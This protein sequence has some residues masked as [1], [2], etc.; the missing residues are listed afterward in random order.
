MKDE[1]KTKEQLINELV[2]LRRLF[3]EMEALEVRGTEAEDFIA[4]SKETILNSL[5]EHVIHQ[6]TEMKILW[7]NRA[8]C[9]SAGLALE[10]L[11][12]CHCYEIWPQRTDPCPGCPVLKAMKTGQR[13]EVEKITPDG[14]AR[15][16]QGSPVRD[17]N[18][19]VIGGIE[20]TLDIT[21]RKLV[22]EALRKSE[23]RYR[24]IVEDQT[25]MI[26]RFLPGGILTFVNDAYCRCCGKKREELIGRSFMSLIPEE[27][28]AVVE[29]N[30]ALLTQDSPV[31]TS[32]HQV[33][34]PDG[35]TGW[36]Q[37]SDRAIFN[38]KG[39]FIEYQSVGRDI[40]ER[41]RMEEALQK[42]HLILEQQVKERTAELLMKNEQLMKEIEERRQAERMLQESENKYRTVFETTGTATVIIEEDKIIS[43][44]NREFEKLSGYSKEEVEGKKSWTEFVAEDDLKK[45]KEY[46]RMRRLDSNA[47]PRNYEFEFIDRNGNVKDIFMTVAMI[48]GT[49][50]SVASFLDITEHKRMDRAL[51]ESERKYRLI[52]DNVSDVIWTID[53]NLRYTYVSPSVTHL[54]GY[55][56]EEVMGQTVEMVLTPASLDIANKALAEELNMESKSQKDLSRSRVLE[57]EHICKDGSTVRVEIKMTFLRD[58]EGRSVG[59]LGVTRDITDRKRAE[60]ALHESEDQLRFLSSQL[61]TTQENERKRIAQELHDSIGQILTTI[62]FGVENV[63]SPRSKV[64]VPP[65]VDVKKVRTL[66]LIAQNG[67]EE[68]RRICAD[69]WPSILD[70]LGIPAAISRLC[71]EFQIIY[72]DIHIEQQINVQ[73]NEVPDFLKIV[74]YRVLQEALNNIARHSEAHLVYVSLNKTKDTIELSVKDN[75]KGFNIKDVFYGDSFTRRL[76]SFNMKE[77]TELS[78]GS[79][80]VKSIRGEGTTILSSWYV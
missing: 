75:G 9:E 65:D 33:I 46:H 22:E 27:D 80:V 57:L 66:I 3:A 71:R 47:A 1:E 62:K 15:V 42:S 17:S 14:R 56:V 12:G 74:I 45:M 55:G 64:T 59:I 7:A 31:A 58:S 19:N 51:Q 11:V 34:L 25:E 61:L 44:A 38:N 76:G 30:L 36:Q 18:G 78:G 8:A 53:M 10:E 26:C 32:K 29:K 68:I 2:E 23:A 70:D 69:L 50:R 60:D 13:Q 24:H 6:S 52:A 37:W 16:I 28:H 39:K 63:I 21:E 4:V 54:L 5:M 40:T 49:K 48:T 35:E 73:E 79:F 72:S 43:L 77:R 41:K 67:I 20:V